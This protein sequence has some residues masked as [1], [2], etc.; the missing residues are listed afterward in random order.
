MFS[1]RWRLRHVVWIA[2]VVAVVA[3]ASVL[4]MRLQARRASVPELKD[5]TPLRPG[6]SPGQRT[7]PRLEIDH[8]LKE[9]RWLAHNVLPPKPA[10]KMSTRGFADVM[11]GIV[12]R[13][14]G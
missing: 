6:R 9:C 11:S 10:P 2:A 1:G 5:V 14:K 7:K 3:I 12:H 8:V 13:K 4:I